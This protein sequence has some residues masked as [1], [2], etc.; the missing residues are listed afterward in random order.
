MIQ[1]ACS[2]NN[3]TKSI[4]V[5][6]SEFYEAIET[7]QSMLD[8]A[9]E[10]I[11]N[12]WDEVRELFNYYEEELYYDKE[13]YPPCRVRWTPYEIFADKRPHIHRCRDHCYKRVIYAV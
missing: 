2:Y 3:S 12:A 7:L 8:A 5:A 13:P 10:E 6:I 1:V 4:E 9:R 11:E